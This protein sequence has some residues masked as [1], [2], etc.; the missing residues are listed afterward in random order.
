MSGSPGT[1]P[2]PVSGL[3]EPATGGGA[4]RQRGSFG[5]V[6][7]GL[8]SVLVSRPVHSVLSAVRSRE[9]VAALHRNAEVLAD[10]LVLAG[11]LGLSSIIGLPC[12]AEGSITSHRGLVADDLGHV[13]RRRRRRGHRE[14][15]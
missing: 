3:P 7:N 10:G 2:G 14:Q 9:H 1:T 6:E 4:R 5:G 13:L 8:E 12:V 11:G 15:R